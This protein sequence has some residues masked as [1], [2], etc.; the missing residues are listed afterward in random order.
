M[1][2]DSILLTFFFVATTTLAQTPILVKDINPG[3]FSGISTTTNATVIGNTLYFNA[4]G[5]I[6]DDELWKT[7]GTESGTVLVKDINVGSGTSFQKFYTVFKNQ[8][9][10]TAETPLYGGELWR[11]DDTE[12]QYWQQVM[13]ALEFVAG[14]FMAHQKS[15]LLNLMGICFSN[16]IMNYGCLM[17]RPQAQTF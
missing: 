11:T 3:V 14:L 6:Q 7:D 8:L 12:V 4:V 1:H 16:S 17:A 9:Y 15:C 2:K 5:T 13:F 10:L